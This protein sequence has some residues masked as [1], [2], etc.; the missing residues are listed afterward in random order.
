MNSRILGVLEAQ[1]QRDGGPSTLLE[2]YRILLNVEAEARNYV[3]VDRHAIS[4][5]AARS[6][7]YRGTPLLA[8]DDFSFDWGNV[9]R[10]F[11]EV[12]R[13]SSSHLSLTAQAAEALH[14]LSEDV[15]ALRRAARDWY[16]GESL[17]PL[18]TA[19]GVSTHALASV[20]ANTMK[21]YLTAGAETVAQLV[22]QE[23]WRRGYCPICGGRAD[24]AFLD[25]ETGAR[26]LLCAR[27][28]SQ[29]LFQRLECPYCGNNDQGKLSYLIDDE[30][31]YRLY[32]CESCK[33]YLKAL[34]LR[35]GGE[36]PLLPLERLLTLDLDRQGRD[37]GYRPGYFVE[38]A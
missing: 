32:L 1:E 30:E 13:L 10:V 9:Q 35:H 6:C 22:D 37:A 19:Y 34:D 2:A 17:I 25:K 28:D 3:A 21:P 14:R 26:W 4:L 38:E 18:A 29:W 12:L 36:E 16:S 31:K 27:C 15:G 7:L 8:F 24:L 11:G 23:S 33:C 5:E 20:I